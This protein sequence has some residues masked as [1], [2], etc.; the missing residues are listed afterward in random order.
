M[1]LKDASIMTAPT[2]FTV[3][4]GSALAF[5]ELYSS[6]EKVTIGV[7]A[8]TDLRLRRT[9]DAHIYQPK[10]NSGAPNGYTQGRAKVVF[11]SP[12]LLDNGAITVNTVK[13]EVA[14]DVETTDAE[15]TELCDIGGQIFIDSDFRALLK[16]LITS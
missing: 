1:S 13:V 11:K 6:G 9:M 4:G 15:R 16:N 3:N 10:P 12:L 5:S 7:S 2:S 14:F 8:D